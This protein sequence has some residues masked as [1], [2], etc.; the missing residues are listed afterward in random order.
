M[1]SPKPLYSHT[2]TFLYCVPNIVL[3]TPR[4][5]EDKIN[6]IRFLDKLNTHLDKKYENT[7]LLTSLHRVESMNFNEMDLH[8]V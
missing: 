7:R 2:Y 3:Q 8:G 5:I 6:E 4:T 1:K